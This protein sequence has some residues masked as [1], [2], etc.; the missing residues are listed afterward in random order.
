MLQLHTG[1]ESRFSPLTLFCLFTCILLMLGWLGIAT[2]P[3]AFLASFWPAN[4]VF[5]GLLAR[6]PQ[7][8]SIYSLLGAFCGYMLADLSTG[9]D[10]LLSTVLTTANMIYVVATLL[11][12]SYFRDFI[13]SLHRGYF[14]LFI[15]LFC[16]LGSLLGASFAAIAVPQI[17]TAFMNGPFLLEVGDWFTAEL[18]NALLLLPIVLNIPRWKKKKFILA[19]IAHGHNPVIHSL[20]LLAVI[21]SLFMSYVDSGPGSL[22]YP[23]AALIWCALTYRHFFVTLITSFA[24]GCIIFWFTKEY[25]VV[26]PQLYTQNSI[27]LRLG[28]IMMAIAPLTVSS[29]DEIRSRLI[30]QLQ[31]NLAYDDLTTCLT[32]R[33]FMESANALLEQMQSKQRYAAVLMLDIDHFKQVNDTYGHQA[34]DIAL[35]NC[36]EII[37]KNLRSY[38]LLGRLGGEEFA[39]LLIDTPPEY[40]LE[41]AER[42]RHN[43]SQK[44]IEISPGQM[45][46]IQTSIGVH[47][48]PP[49]HTDSI[50]MCLKQA[51]DALYQA[52]RC[53][54]N[55]VITAN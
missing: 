44:Q 19:P 52:K 29:I 9:S 4:S 23:I 28:I 42:I 18:Q 27:S 30:R 47:I 35:R 15:F 24:C 39:A 25:L 16:T 7:T 12:Y 43:L 38:D 14:Y 1:R 41:I 13:H 2:R 50:E 51:D 11:L 20:P 22:L 33:Q 8:R 31:Y 55:Q 49:Q 53:G 32:R 3:H 5:L 17:T 45:I 40:A 48:C 26:Y 37:Q 36:A 46:R 10:L 54:R 6:Y 21:F 34:G